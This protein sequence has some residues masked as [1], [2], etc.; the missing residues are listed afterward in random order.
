MCAQNRICLGKFFY[1]NMF[2]ELHIHINLRSGNSQ[3]LFDKK[4]HIHMH[5]LWSLYINDYVNLEW[6]HNV[7]I[8]SETKHADE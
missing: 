8:N 3:V 6:M 2:S 5:N 1:L 7:N 4:E